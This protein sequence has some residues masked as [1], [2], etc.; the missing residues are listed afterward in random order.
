MSKKKAKKHSEI[1]LCVESV[2]SGLKL[3]KLFLVID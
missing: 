3:C 1:H 2:V